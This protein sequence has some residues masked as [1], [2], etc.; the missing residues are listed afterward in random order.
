MNIVEIT[1]KAREL[2]S[3][4]DAILKEELPTEAQI[5][6]GEV[7]AAELRKLDR[8]RELGDEQER[9]RKLDL[10]VRK[11]IAAS[12]DYPPKETQSEA[13]ADRRGGV[14][15]RSGKDIVAPLGQGDIADNGAFYEA[16]LSRRYDP[17][18]EKY[19][20]RATTLADH[21]DGGYLVPESGTVGIFDKAVEGTV[22]WPRTTTYSVTNARSIVIP[23]FDDSDHS[24]GTLYGGVTAYWEPEAAELTETAGAVREMRLT[25]KGLKTYSTMSNEFVVSGPGLASV[26]ERKLGEAIGWKIDDA[27]LRGDGA[28]KPLGIL[29][30]PALVTVD[31]ETSQADDTIL[32]ANIKNMY[33]RML[34]ASKS[35]A[36]W[37]CNNDLVP[38]LLSLTQPVG[39]AGVPVPVMNQS[40][41][42]F[43][44]LGRP[45]IFT[46]KCSALG[47]VGD[48]LFADMSYYAVA[49]L[50]AIT[51]AQSE[52]A[53]FAH[54]KHAIRATAYIDGQ[55]LVDSAFTPYKGSLSMS[56]FVALGAR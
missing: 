48:I 53:F 35:R 55:P 10:P 17:R 19:E 11:S 56:P 8:L 44:I 6:R 23:A 36:V 9:Q 4:L 54:D 20:A 43:T 45:V 24:G 50:G 7:V 1:S 47:D 13:R 22:F 52:H 33:A 38:Q 39:T 49:M 18:L 34:P 21:V 27:I 2:R 31:E 16:V 46:E 51:L 14:Q 28:G 30:S 29:N 32:W 41:G 12:E 37:Y 15:V 3:E 5:K 42:E 25:P 40:N 26:I